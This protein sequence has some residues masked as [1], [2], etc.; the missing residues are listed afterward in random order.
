MNKQFMRSFTARFKSGNTILIDR[1]MVP[2]EEA[3]YIVNTHD[4]MQD[5]IE[6][7]TA[8]NAELITALNRIDLWNDFSPSE[9]CDLGSWGEHKCADRLE[10][11][12]RQLRQQSTISGE[13][14]E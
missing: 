9:K 13:D 3:E 14:N 8:Q 10:E 5:R 7:L 1:A 12:A 11:Q 6:A 4:A 2:R